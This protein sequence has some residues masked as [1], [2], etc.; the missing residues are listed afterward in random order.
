MILP[1]FVLKSRKN[2]IWTE[3][4]MDTLEHCADKMHFK[5]YP[6]SVM[7][8]YNNRG[9][10]DSDWSDSVEELQNA[11]WCVGDSFTVGLGSPVDHTWVNILQKRINKRCINVS[12]D[13]ASNNWIARKTLSIL[14]EIQPKFIII[15]WSFFTRGEL[16][17][18][19]LD[20]EERRLNFYDLDLTS[21]QLLVN[22]NELVQSV[23]Q[24]KQDTTIIHS[25]IP[26]WSI[27][28][29]GTSVQEI[30]NKLRGSTWPDNPTNQ[31][32]EVIKEELQRFGHGEFFKL[33]CDILDSITYV[34]E[35]N[36]LDLA[37]DGFH[38]DKITATNFVDQLEKLI[39]NLDLS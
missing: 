24:A 29:G 9:F 4:G 17:G 30:W 33:Y 31:I 6:Y 21:E 13:G 32:T 27:G 1:D 20:D 16:P 12:L 39:L 15:H 14:K 22:F 3:S 7:Y 25:F 5:N 23:E 38:Y 28:T 2:K 19:D 34:P 37:R 35:L 10:R 18:Q 8:N 26:S 36:I 11:V